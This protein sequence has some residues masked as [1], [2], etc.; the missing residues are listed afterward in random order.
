MQLYSTSVDYKLL[1]YPF[2]QF[3]RHDTNDWSRKK[4]SVRPQSPFQK[5]KM[6]VARGYI[7]DEQCW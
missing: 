6:R 3:K 1:V 7:G 4:I 2:H 5:I